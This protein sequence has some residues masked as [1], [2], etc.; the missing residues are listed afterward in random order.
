MATRKRLRW[1]AILCCH[2]IANLASY[3]GGWTG[4][5]LT[6]K[7]EFWKRAN[8]NFMDIAVLE[9]CKLFADHRGFHCYRKVLSN[10]DEFEAELL[11]DLEISAADFKSYCANLRTYRDKFIAHLDD[12]P[13]AKYPE[14]DVAI[15]STK[16][17]FSYLRT[18]EDRN[19]YLDGL[20]RNLESVYR[21]AL[22][23]AKASYA[24][25]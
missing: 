10:S 11:A 17:L 25:K 4:R 7:E 20:P 1:T 16:F 21:L 18:R 5:Q 14:L 19:G 13:K 3:R 2:A 23:E 12:D 9:W 15:K 8:G 22:N 6:R 24:E